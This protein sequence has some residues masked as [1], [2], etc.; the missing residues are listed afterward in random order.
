MDRQALYL[1]DLGKSNTVKKIVGF[2]GPYFS[3][4]FSPDGKQ[5]AFLSWLGQPGFFYA[6]GHIAVV[7]VAKV[8]DRMA[9]TPS[10]VL[11]LTTRF[12]EVP[13]PVAWAPDGIY[14]TAYQKTDVKLF[15]VNPQTGD[16]RQ[17]S[18][19]HSVIE[20]VSFTRDFKTMAFIAEDSSHMTELYVS[21]MDS[22]SPRKLTNTTSQVTEWNLG[23]PSVISWKS[24]D[25]TEIEGVLY[26][27]EDFDPNRK[28]PLFVDLHP[29]PADMSRPI[30][31]PAEYAQPLQ[32]FLA[33]GALVLKPNYRGSAGYGAAFRKLNVRNLGMG[34]MWDVMSGVDHL[35]A[36]GMVDPERLAAM[37]SSWGGYISAFLA[38]HTDRFKAILG[39]SGV[40][41]TRTNYVTTDVTPF[42]PQYL[43]ATPWDDPEIYAK[44]SSIT[45]IKQA[46]TPTLIQHGIH[47]R[48]VPVENA[49]ELYRGLQDQGVDSRLILYP[50]FGHGV[51]E[52]KS[53]RAVV[54]SNLDWFNYYIWNEPIPKDSPLWGTSEF[55]VA[56]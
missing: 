1:L 30:L 9:A 2:P 11:D 24:Q 22:F 47:D 49:Y 46:K 5:L 10:D 21:S 48:R 14:F 25:G 35:I 52:P 41:D 31:S 54:Q 28:Y 50:G 23:T 36:N 40:S 18:A 26:K 17:I 15:R 27:P 42:L 45:T 19:N 43:G 38:T 8:L 44:T 32:L 20:G 6:N 55:A 39:S 16:I 34:E 3:L 37:G 33:K 7:D 13:S 12:D 51:A 4:M 56:K 53:M 29:G